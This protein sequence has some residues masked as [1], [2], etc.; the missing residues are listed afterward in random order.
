MLDELESRII[1]DEE[2]VQLINEII[3]LGEGTS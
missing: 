3:E 2:N 1:L